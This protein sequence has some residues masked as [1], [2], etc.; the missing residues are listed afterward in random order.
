MTTTITDVVTRRHGLATLSE[1]QPTGYL[2]W[3]ITLI[4]TPRQQGR[5]PLHWKAQVQEDVIIPLHEAEN[6]ATNR[7]EWGRFFKEAKGHQVLSS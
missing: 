5:P 3:S 1:C 6:L 4:S 2:T 7:P